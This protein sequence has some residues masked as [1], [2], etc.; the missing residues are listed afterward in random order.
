MIPTSRTFKQ[1]PSCKL[2][3][4]T[5]ILAAFLYIFTFRQSQCK[6]ACRGEN[7]VGSVRSNSVAF[8]FQRVIRTNPAVTFRSTSTISA[9]RKLQMSTFNKSPRQSHVGMEFSGSTSELSGTTTP[10]RQF[11]LSFGAGNQFMKNYSIPRCRRHHHRQRYQAP[12]HRR[13]HHLPDR[14]QRH[15]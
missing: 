13:N 14:R 10:F 15:R 11:R 9:E 4:R 12:G 1:S 5:K 8:T 3:A 6:I 7:T 2:A